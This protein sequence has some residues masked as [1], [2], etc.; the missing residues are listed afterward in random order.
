MGGKIATGHIQPRV[1]KS[2]NGIIIYV[3]ERSFIAD[4]A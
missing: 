1:A 3:V 4:A 2:E